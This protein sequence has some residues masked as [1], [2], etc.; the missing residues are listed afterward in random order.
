MNGLNEVVRAAAGALGV[1]L[2][3]A[4]CRRSGPCATYRYLPAKSDGAMQAWRLNVRVFAPS[5]AQAARESEKLRKA[6]VPDGDTGVIG[7]GARMR[8]VCAEDEGGSCGFV[9]GTQMYYVQSGFLI[10]SRA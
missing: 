6:L 4:P 7:E 8:V 5:A 1:P 9:R 2:S 3:P 10:R